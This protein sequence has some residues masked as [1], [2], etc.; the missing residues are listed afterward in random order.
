M[1]S[2]D[3]DF[4]KQVNERQKEVDQLL[5]HKSYEKA[6]K[7]ALTNP[8]IG[9]KVQSTKDKNL[10]TVLRAI[11]AT[12]EKEME[13]IIK[14]ISNGPGELSNTLMKYIYRGLAEGQGSGTLLKWH[15]KTVE[16]AGHG[17]II[18]CMTDRKTV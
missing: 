17:T 4:F 12:P 7:T 10:Q 9:C 13:A 18:R 3:A 6:L 11:S 2:S 1:S 15:A 16:I 5:T 8:P 14:S